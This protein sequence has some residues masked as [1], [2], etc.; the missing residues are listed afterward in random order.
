LVVAAICALSAVAC[1]KTIYWDVT[2]PESQWGTIGIKQEEPTFAVLKV[3]GAAQYPTAEGDSLPFGG[4]FEQLAIRVMP[5]VHEVTLVCRYKVSYRAYRKSWGR[6]LTTRYVEREVTRK[7]SLGPGDES[8]LDSGS[9]CP[10]DSPCEDGECE[11][12]FE[13]RELK[14]YPVPKR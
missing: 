4:D 3:D 6:V 2:G 14:P 7:V 13:H 12:V 1:A 5:G 10:P 8:V 9:V 11:P